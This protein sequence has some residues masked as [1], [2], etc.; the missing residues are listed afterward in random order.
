MYRS[1][2]NGKVLI[3]LA[4]CTVIARRKNTIR[5]E[6]GHKGTYGSFIWQ[7]S[8]INK[9]YIN[10][11]NEKN[12]IKEMDHISNLLNTSLGYE[13]DLKSKYLPKY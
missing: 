10:F 4:K 6:T 7:A 2:K 13:D 1:Y 8:F 3:N 9:K 5:F 12:A 11:V